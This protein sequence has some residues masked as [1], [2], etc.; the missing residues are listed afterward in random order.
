MMDGGTAR[1]GIEIIT[2]VDSIQRHGVAAGEG[3]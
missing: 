1:F 3:Q 2:P